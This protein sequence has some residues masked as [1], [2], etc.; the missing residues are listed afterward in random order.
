MYTL[1]IATAGV[2][3]ASGLLAEAQ[4]GD[5]SASGFA[6]AAIIAAIGTATASIIA[7][8]V[9]LI[10]ALRKSQPPGGTKRRR[11][12]EEAFLARRRQRADQLR[13]EL[14]KVMDDL[15]AIDE[16]PEP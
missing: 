12:S 10:T 3:T 8:V 16:E 9:T 14:E 13:A 5:P 4:A 6:I 15:L 1:I 7:A 11:E 2:S